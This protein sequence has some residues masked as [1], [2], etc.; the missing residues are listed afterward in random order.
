[1]HGVCPVACRFRAI[2]LHRLPPQLGGETVNA[3]PHTPSVQGRGLFKVHTI[4]GSIMYA[5]QHIGQILRGID[6]LLQQLIALSFGNGSSR[7]ISY[8]FALIDFVSIPLSAL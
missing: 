6:Q 2:S 4:G 8:T 1:M 3:L 7:F 5:Q